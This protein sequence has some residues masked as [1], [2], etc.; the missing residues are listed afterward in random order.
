M[1]MPGWMPVTIYA[2]IVMVFIGFYAWRH[3]DDRL[4]RKS[5][6]F[7]VFLTGFQLLNDFVSRFYVYDGFPQW[8]IV[9]CTYINFLV[10]PAIGIGWYQHMRSVIADDERRGTARLDLVVY[11]LAAIG[12]AAIVVNPFMGGVF[13]FDQAGLYSRGPLFFVPAGSAFL[14]ILI[15][16]VYLFTRIRSLG[17]RTLNTLL[18]F[19]VP[20]I[21]GAFAAM[22]VYGLPWMPLG[23][24]ISMI[25]LF[26]SAMTSDMNTDFLTSISNRRRIVELLQ[27]R[28]DTARGGGK[29]FAAMMVD[30]DDFKNINDTLGHAVGDRA[31]S[32]TARLL[33]DCLQVDDVVGR[34]GGDEFLVLIDVKSQ[35]ELEA[36]VCHITEREQAR[37]NATL[38]YRLCLSK[39]YAMFDP[40][41]FSTC[42]EFIRYLDELMYQDKYTRKAHME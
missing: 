16:E 37:N 22:A 2:I 19:P 18:F 13:S 27:E 24:S 14:C 3:L 36:V 33:K 40:K 9:L 6:V 30:V 26:A 41:R 17:R 39:G 1:D 20:P 25:V 15:A 35:E 10:L 31:L 28:V 29:P 23:I 8:A 12:L 32:D 42:E 11:A 34:Y 21:L 4:G 7:L 5:F 38:P